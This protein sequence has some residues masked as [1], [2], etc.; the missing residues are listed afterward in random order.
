MARDGPKAGLEVRQELADARDLAARDR[1]RMTAAV[2][3]LRLT[4]A[5]GASHVE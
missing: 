3:F 1:E 4:F 2:R 5:T